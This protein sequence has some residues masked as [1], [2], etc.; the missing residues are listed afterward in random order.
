MS[1]SQP[2]CSAAFLGVLLW[3]GLG[4]PSERAK[5]KPDNTVV[6]HWP[7]TGKES[8]WRMRRGGVM[9]GDIL[10]MDKGCAGFLADALPD[11]FFY[12]LKRSDTPQGPVFRNGKRVV[13]DFPDETYFYIRVLPA[14]CSEHDPVPLQWGPDVPEFLKTPRGEAAYIKDGRT[15]PLEVGL[16]QEGLEQSALGRRVYVWWFYRFVVKTKGV[17]LSDPV[18]FSLHSRDGRKLA[19]FTLRL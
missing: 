2:S 9:G 14:R 4:L 12:G 16:A 13:A 7:D 19:Q 6:D 5:Q 3:W 10:R 11:E 15:Q 17:H 8:V 1:S 18:V